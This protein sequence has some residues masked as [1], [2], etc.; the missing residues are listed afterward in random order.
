MPHPAYQVKLNQF[1]GPLEKLLELIEE[2]K[3]EVTTISLGAVTNDF[4]EYL[5]TLDEHTKHPSV[6]ADFVVI[7]SRLLLIKSKALL[8][9]LEL[10]QE[11]TEDIHNLE[12]R[13]KIYQEFKKASEHLRQLWNTPTSSY[14]RPYFMNLPP[15]FYPP[16]DLPLDRLQQALYKI[17][18]ELKLLI[19]E[20]KTI[21]R[22]LMSIEEKVKELLGRLQEQAAH[23][24]HSLSGSKSK[25]EVIV[26]FLA[27]LHLLRDRLIHTEQTDQF[28]DIII[29]NSQS[30]L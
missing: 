17:L 23:S 24:F 14:A 3:L 11:E 7:A 8:P 5:R 6:L 15:I 2:K 13:L 12:A 30:S 22:V 19:P 28:S 27:V 10:T 21:K 4:L 20:E 18:Q 25:L 26:L 16:Q 9:T 29:T 1:S